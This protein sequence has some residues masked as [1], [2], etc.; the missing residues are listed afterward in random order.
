MR[1]GSANRRRGFTLV[2]TVVTVGIVAALAAVV[3]PTVVKQFDAAD[4]TKAAEDL[5]NIRT[6]IETFGVNVRPQQPDDLED[7]V[8]RPVAGG[9]SL[10]S[11]ARGALYTT[12]EAAA[13]NGPYLSASTLTDPGNEATVLTTGFGATIPS[14]FGLF[15]VGA[16]LAGGDT[17]ST[18]S[19]GSADFIAIRML[20]LSGTAFNALNQ[21]IDGPTENTA[22]LRRQNG[23]LRCPHGTQG[24][25]AIA[26][27][28][29]FYLASPIR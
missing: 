15:D 10:D 18:G 8:L 29:A 2:E 24:D 14:H 3:Y 19:V 21:L 12:S 5:G 16:A 1:K 9:G 22:V 28:I 27:P 13:W 11:T 20:G 23:I 26:C 25:D 4:P 17:V 6:A 7:L